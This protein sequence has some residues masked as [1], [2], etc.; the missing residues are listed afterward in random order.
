M[1]WWEMNAWEPWNAEQHIWAQGL[2]L[3]VDRIQNVHVFQESWFCN[4]AHTLKYQ[5]KQSKSGIDW[6]EHELKNRPA[7]RREQGLVQ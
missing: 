2:S 1:D 4:Q 5:S 6:I 3:S 7:G